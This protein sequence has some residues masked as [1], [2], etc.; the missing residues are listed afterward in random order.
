M[1][2]VAPPDPVTRIT[3]ET[4]TN[5][6]GITVSGGLRIQKGGN[7][8]TAGL[9]IMRAA[10]EAAGYVYTPG[11]GGDWVAT[12]QSNG[13]ITVSFNNTPDVNGKW[14]SFLYHTPSILY[15]YYQVDGDWYELELSQT[16]LHP[17]PDTRR[18]WREINILLPLGTLQTVEFDGVPSDYGVDNLTF[19]SQ[20]A[21]E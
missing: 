2:G 9:H 1:V 20:N 16:P 7:I 19:G 12:N 18:N 10:N 14:F 4:T 11:A 3:F 17:G 21:V 8:P 5:P 6:P 13:I 15:V